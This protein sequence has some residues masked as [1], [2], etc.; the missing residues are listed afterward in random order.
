RYQKGAAPR[1]EKGANPLGLFGGLG[2]TVLDPTITP[3]FLCYARVELEGEGGAPARKFLLM[4]DSLN[5]LRKAVQQ[6]RAPKSSLAE[7]NRFKEM[8]K[9][10]RE[11]RYDFN[12]VDLSKLVDIYGVILPYMGRTGLVNRET[13]NQM[14][15][16]NALRPH[17]YPMAWASS[18]VTDPEGVVVETYSPTG[19]LPLV[20]LLGLTAWPVIVDRQAEVVSRQIDQNYKKV[21]LG[22]HLY[23]A[24][25]DRFP[26]Q[27]SDLYPNYVSDISVFESPFKRGELSKDKTAQIDPALLNN[28]EYTN[29]VYVPGRSLQ[30]KGDDILVWEKEPT[31]LEKTRDGS[32]LFHHVV[33][34]DGKK[35]WLTRPGLDLRL[36]G[37][38]DYITA[39][40][41]KTKAADKSKAGAQEGSGWLDR[42]FNPE[43]EVP[44]RA[45]V[46]TEGG[47]G[48]A[49]PDAEKPAATDRPKIEEPERPKRELPDHLKKRAP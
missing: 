8:Q 7:D 18:L 15:S 24:D 30:D 31:R 25:F 46:K 17:I 37:R 44:A 13:L 34:I 45:P 47:D 32:Q 48:D 23:A 6:S 3:F 21:M 49:A 16:P 5:A 27:L 35:A 2:A 33:T 28:P 26:Q 38:V 29:M 12:F 20:T 19:N 36:A 11:S 22:L 39:M 41:E 40:A 42:L 4:S 1:E 9:S 43:P 10:L 14:P